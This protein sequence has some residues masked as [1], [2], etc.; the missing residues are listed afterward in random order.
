MSALAAPAVSRAPAPPSDHSSLVRTGPS[1]SAAVRTGLVTRAP[2]RPLCAGFLHPDA[3]HSLNMAPAPPLPVLHCITCGYDL[4]GLE[5][6]RLCPE[7][8]TPIE[9]SRFLSTRV[10]ITH[11]RSVHAGTTLLLI[12][13]AI[14]PFGWVLAILATIGYGQRA[15]AGI[16]VMAVWL[17]AAVCWPIGWW[18]V[19]SV[20]AGTPQRRR[21]IRSTAL[22][23]LI[24]LG[25]PLIGFLSPRRF[26]EILSATLFA[27]AA[28][29]G[30]LWIN[31]FLLIGD[32]AT[33]L[34]DLSLRDFARRTAFALPVLVGI[35][36]VMFPIAA[37]IAPVATVALMALG[38]T[39]TLRLRAR[40][41]ALQVM[42][43]GAVDEAP[44]VATDPGPAD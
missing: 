9:R 21:W 5:H 38:T 31:G 6:S 8:A 40:L 26:A 17:A 39:T 20:S 12:S 27:G 11:R 41:A 34:F 43:D 35:A 29:S 36:L 14:V 28:S 7:C 30:L 25:L 2:T 33:V 10:S 15:S 44:P 22:L 32:V 1:A 23:L 37:L 24:M 16:A 3:V 19:S 4:A 13:F 18:F 42:S